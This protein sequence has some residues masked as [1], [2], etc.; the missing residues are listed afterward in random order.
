V[1]I[2][3][4]VVAFLVFGLVVDDI[5]LNKLWDFQLWWWDFWL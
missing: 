4:L 3:V 2:A 1:G 5:A